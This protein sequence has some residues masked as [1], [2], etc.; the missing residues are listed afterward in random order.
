MNDTEN[1]PL[2]AIEREI[3][4]E[5]NSILMDILGSE[6]LAKA[7]TNPF[8]YAVGLR[9]GVVIRFESLTILGK[10]WVHL[11]LGGHGRPTE[12]KRLPYPAIRGVD[13]RLSDIIWAM[14]APEGS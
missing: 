11:A 13:V 10:D 4:D 14:D 12:G 5:K 8:D 7:A 9:T 1:T 3:L 2:A 6:A